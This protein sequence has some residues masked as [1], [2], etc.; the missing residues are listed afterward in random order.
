VSKDKKNRKAANDDPYANRESSNYAQ[1]IA[2]REYIIELIKN[3]SYSDRRQLIKRLSIKGQVA[4]EALR[5]RLNAMV[6]DGQLTYR[7]KNDSFHIPNFD[8]YISGKVE[9]HR[10]GY[11]FLL[12]ENDED[13]FLSEREMR[14]VFHGDEVLV[15]ILGKTR[16][17]G[18]EGKIEKIINRANKSI[19]GRVNFDKK[20]FFVLPD[21]PRINHDIFLPEGIEEFSVEMGDYVEVDITRYPTSRRVAQGKIKKVLGGALAPGLEID[22]AIHS[23]DIPNTWSL[24]VISQ[25]EKISKEPSQADKENRVDLRDLPFVT[26]DG[27]DAKDFDDAV[28]CKKNTSGGFT[29]WVS[30]ADVSFYVPLGTPLDKAAYDRGTSVYFPGRVIPM[31][32]EKISNGL[33]SLK[34]QLDRLSITCEMKIDQK[35][36]LVDFDFYESVIHSHG[37]LTYNE[38]AEVLG[39]VKKSPRIGLT[40]RL[41]SLL[42]SLKNLFN[43]YKLLRDQ[44]KS[45]GA[46]DFETVETQMIFNQEK[47]IES[48]QP[49]IRN[50]A[51][52]IIEECMLCANVAAARFLSKQDMPTLFRVHESPKESKLESLKLYLA[53]LNLRLSG[54]LKPAPSDYQHIM[55][56]IK[57]RDDENLIQVMLLRSMNQAVY[58]PQNEGHFGLAY[59]AYLHFTSPIRRYPDLIIHRAIRSLIR[60]NSSCNHIR[61]IDDAPNI[62]K[63][64]IYPYTLP[65]MIEIGI[66][67]SMTERR[68][69]DAT[70]DV[71]SW[72]KCEYLMERLGEKLSGLITG[73]TRFGIFVELD[74]LFVEGLVHINNLGADFFRFNE[75]QQ[76]M[77]GEKSGRIFALGQRLTVIVSRVDLSE[78]RIDLT[79]PSIGLP[80]KN[81]KRSIKKKSKVKNKSKKIK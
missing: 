68:A 81:K 35:G 3:E 58:Q 65:H 47:K 62:Q 69:E 74:D 16:R 32:P 8:E 39:L 73:V 71:I 2:S 31:L 18:I 1:P 79:L 43:L 7:K 46:I 19:V 70:R 54:G 12:I 11:G 77:V 37:R 75:S 17:G 44:R 25:I 26:I 28:F 42:P 15:S 52:K 66:H 5:R 63:K 67:A 9:A 48:I 29:L 24:G 45:R 51:H 22:L 23:F 13:I 41:D 50:E 76:K 38:V 27:E 53:E 4:R 10:D 59:E 40:K 20:N 34:P 6:R 72:L 60:S 33:C 64:Q 49:V 14:K 61:R 56:L 36:V 80:R 30:I 57:G 55:E 78:R 21:N